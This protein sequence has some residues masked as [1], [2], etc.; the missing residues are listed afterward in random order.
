MYISSRALF[1]FNM[2]LYGSYFSCC[3][4]C[5]LPFFLA[6]VAD[7]KG[8]FTSSSAAAP[9]CS[10]SPLRWFMIMNAVEPYTSLKKEGFL[11]VLQFA[12][13]PWW[14][15]QLMSSS[16]LDQAGGRR[17]CRTR[18]KND[19]DHCCH[20]DTKH[21]SWIIWWGS[22]SDIIQVPYNKL[23]QLDLRVASL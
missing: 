12:A 5:C 15:Y 10:S 11:N 16:S 3:C 22:W 7:K 2:N 19:E 13:A 9:R 14:W 8:A 1:D 6:A 20:P 21:S 17:L 4:C 18:W 23:L